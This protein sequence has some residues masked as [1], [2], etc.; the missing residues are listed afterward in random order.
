GVVFMAGF[1][2]AEGDSSA[3]KP[4]T[5]NKI[6]VQPSDDEAAKALGASLDF[7]GWIIV[8]D[9]WNGSCTLIRND[10]EHGAWILTARHVTEGASSIS[11][12]F[13][14][15]A[16]DVSSPTIEADSRKIFNH[17]NY[18]VDAALVKLRV[19]PQEP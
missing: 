6:W 13:S 19:P 1:G 11:V 8:D 14:S 7:L 4:T 5:Q 2:W 10:A 17:S 12:N 3:T 16:Y 15:R 9:D 18:F